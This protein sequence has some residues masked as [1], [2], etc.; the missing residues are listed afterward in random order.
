M[1]S[2]FAPFS[3][4][5]NTLF[6]E[7]FDD[8]YSSAKGAV[9]ECNHV[10][11]KGNNLKERFEN[12]GE[13][14]KF[15][16]GEIGFGIGINFLTTCKSWLD[17]TKQNQVLE[18]YSFDKYLFRL[19]DFKTLN[20]SCPDLKE[21]ISELER[22][23]PRNI[24][25]AQKISLFGGRIILNLIIGEIDNTQEY[26][27]LM[28][29]VD[30]WYFD[31]FSPSKNP[32]L[33][34]I[35]LFKCI[36]KSC[37]ENTTFSTYTSSGLVKNNLTESGFNHSRAMGFS[38]KRHMLKGTVDTQL[39]KNTSNTKVA[40][41]GSGIAGCVLSYTLAKKGIEVD[42]YEKSDSICS[43]AS[44]HELLVTYPRLSAHDTAFGSF[45]LHSYIFATNFYKQ[46]KTDAW[47]KTG[48]IILNHD[49]A[50]E[51]RQSSLLEKRADGE[52]Y[53]YIDPDEA[54]E[55]SGIDIKLNGLIY[56][57]AGYILPEEMCKFLIESP[58]INIFTSSHIKSI[59][60]NREF[61]NLNIGEKKF[62]YQNVCVC[63][64]SETAN[65]VDIDGISIKRG[66]VTHI[67]SLDNV[68]R[69][70]LPICAKGYISPRVNNIHLV[71]SSYSDSEDTDLSE[72]EH[73]YNLNNL[74]LVIDEEMNVIT[75]QTGHRAVS[76]DHMPVVGMK[77]GI[78][79]NTCHG[80][81]ASVTA[82]ISAEIIASMIVDEAPPLMGRELESLS[83]ERFN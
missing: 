46:L 37:H 41:I 33:W 66:Q 17:H 75:G 36:H 23:Y 49:E 48:V 83:P 53:R 72:E 56:E 16:I 45:T 31:G 73:L 43:G 22:N 9:A 28:D 65:I 55:I 52:I 2:K 64:G 35:K 74:K 5:N 39:K 47:K 14:S 6:S 38:D 21:Y 30:A 19:S 10:F 13:N 63:A 58:K 59:K 8:L 67:E 26:I 40:V 20:V 78:Y 60:K 54:S 69:I 34:S 82:P 80:S 15:Y 29:K 44:S 68:S 3:L 79:I 50:T 1:Y 32:D 7:E 61:F 4:K 62:E 18:F 24:Q 70:K 57:D 77:D 71:G 76:K 12:L 25:G 81:R 51:K 42:L 11:I 27:K